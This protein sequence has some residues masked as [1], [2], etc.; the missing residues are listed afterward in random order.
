MPKLTGLLIALSFCLPAYPA[1]VTPEI[2][3]QVRAATFEVVIRKPDQDLLEYEKPLPLEL[4][5]FT[6]RNDKYW[7]VGTAF[8]IGPG[9]FVSAGHVMTTGLGSQ[10]GPPALRD[11]AGKTY[12]VDRVLKY[13]LREDF[14]VFTVIGAAPVTAL[15]LHSG[16][17]LD[18]PVFAVGNALG[19]GVVIRDGLLTSMT[20]ENQDGQWQWMRFSAATSPGN[21]G[22]PLLDAEGRAIGVVI[23]RS[24]GENLNYALPIER[25]LAAGDAAARFDLRESFRLPVLQRTRVAHYRDQFALPLEYREFARRALASRLAWYREQRAALLAEQA[26]ELF[27]LGHSAKLLATDKLP[28][29]PALI[30][31]GKDRQWEANTGLNGERRELPGEGEVVIRHL[32]DAGLFDLRRPA[33]AQDDGFYSDPRAF[34]DMLLKGLVVARPIGSEAVRVTSLGPASRDTR[35]TD[36]FGRIWQLRAW[37]LG[38]ADLDLVVLALPTP[39]GYAGLIRYA[40][41]YIREPAIEELQLLADFFQAPYRGTLGQWQAFLGRRALRPALFEHVTITTGGAQGLRYESPRLK[42][43]VS[44]EV[45]PTSGDSTLTLDVVPLVDG[46]KLVCDIAGLLLRKEAGSATYVDIQRQARPVPAAGRELM[47]RWDQML[48]Q[49]KD[50]DG[51]LGY[52]QD[53]SRFWFRLAVGRARDT[54]GIDPQAATLYS[55]FYETEDRLLPRDLQLRRTGLALGVQVLEP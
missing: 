31:Q 25:V 20:P 8:A 37:P 35:I 43:V 40:T 53:M 33:A 18:D 38:F 22:G 9:T 7:S 48:R 42:A 50:F 3:R 19:D 16:A 34:I 29:R 17:A 21:S 2:Q 39:D 32:D 36:R 23:A 47:T 14:M 49:E 15:E 45:M 12:V 6:E 46:G 30:V 4:L 55:V 51:S 41:S 28:D 24:P 11:S 10:F 5:P 44:P 1:Q 13:S 26:D 27:P 52:N 54:A